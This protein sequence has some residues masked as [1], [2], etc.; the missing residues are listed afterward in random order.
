MLSAT[1]NFHLSAFDSNTN[2][3]AE[4]SPLKSVTIKFIGQNSFGAFF[5]PYVGLLIDEGRGMDRKTKLA[6]IWRWRQ[7]E[8]DFEEEFQVMFSSAQ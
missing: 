5:S 1:S 6:N 2:S 4:I 3:G 8:M 7:K